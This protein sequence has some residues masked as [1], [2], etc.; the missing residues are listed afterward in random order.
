M[1]GDPTG[2]AKRLCRARCKTLIEQD[3]DHAT[4]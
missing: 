1:G 3:V 2:L 4:R